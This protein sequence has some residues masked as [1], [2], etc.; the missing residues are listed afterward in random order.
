MPELPEVE[1]VRQ[2]L[3]DKLTDRIVTQILGEGGRL[4]RHN[5]Q[6]MHDLYAHVEGNRIVDVQ[7]RG[8]SMWLVLGPGDIAFVIHLGMSGQVRVRTR[9]AAELARHE[10]VR[11]VLDNGKK[12]SFVD[13][14]TFGHLTVSPLTEDESGRKVPEQVLTLAPDPL[15]ELPL[16]TWTA[17]LR[18]TRRAVKTAL[19]DQKLVSGIGNIY[20]DEALFA[21]G[22]AGQRPGVSLSEAE[23]EAIVGAA[24]DVMIA[25]LHRR[26]TSFDALYV[27]TE[28]NPGSFSS[29][30]QV[31]SRAGRACPK[32]GSAI[33][34]IVLGGR[35]HFH[36]PSCQP[37][38]QPSVGLKD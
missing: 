32:C 34:R 28:G 4:V 7:R 21:A 6:G 2:G 30:L 15:E 23:A 18:R 31:Y 9:T 37:W 26:G 38:D 12:V 19:L 33:R 8:K 1:T 35:S 27:D 5:P 36:C 22:V 13:Q 20:A 10:H 14:R 29:S 24:R 11:F 17:P 25:A 16:S 3:Q